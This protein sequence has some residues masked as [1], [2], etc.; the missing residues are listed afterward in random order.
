MLYSYQ[1]Q[2]TIADEEVIAMK[3]DKDLDSD[4]ESE[5]DA[6]TDELKDAVNYVNTKISSED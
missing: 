2:Q 3:V 4:E 5:K 6:T 1:L